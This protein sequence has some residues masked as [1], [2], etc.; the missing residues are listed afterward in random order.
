MRTEEYNTYFNAYSLYLKFSRIFIIEYK[1][2]KEIN[3]E[4]KMIGSEYFPSNYHYGRGGINSKN[5]YIVPARFKG[6]WLYNLNDLSESPKTYDNNRENLQECFFRTDY[7]AICVQQYWNGNLIHYEF[8]QNMLLKSS[9]PTILYNFDANL[10]SVMQ[11]EDEL[12]IVG[13]REGVFILDHNS[14]LLHTIKNNCVQTAEVR[15]GILMAFCF[16]PGKYLIVDIRN[17]TQITK[18][19]VTSILLSAYYGNCSPLII[20]LQMGEGA[21]ATGTAKGIEI[22]EVNDDL[23]LTI[24]K[25]WWTGD[26]DDIMFLREL[27]PGI[28]Y[29]GYRNNNKRFCNWRYILDNEAICYN[30]SNEY[31]S[32]CVA[33]CS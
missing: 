19:T 8:D 24:H 11:T 4:Y 14:T 15:R 13:D 23:S 32:D 26:Y 7:E 17:I 5:W 31:I 33:I 16:H 21:F 30:S 22:G 3:R 25:I 18:N 28:I 27:E 12:I 1:G 9:S 29:F 6:F 2:I 20:S 10:Y